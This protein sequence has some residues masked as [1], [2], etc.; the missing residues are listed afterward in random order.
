MFISEYFLSRHRV[1]R[2]LWTVESGERK[3]TSCF[4]W[5]GYNSSLSL[6]SL[7]DDLAKNV[8]CINFSSENCPV[9]PSVKSLLSIRTSSQLF[10][11]CC[12]DKNRILLMNNWF[13]M[14]SDIK[15]QH[16]FIIFS[17]YLHTSQIRREIFE[18][19]YLYR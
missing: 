13:F 15:W 1:K 19:N 4:Y 14:R 6:L 11:F 2:F 8:T 5:C 18:F 9:R 10:F 7:S 16:N 12:G 3:P 17:W